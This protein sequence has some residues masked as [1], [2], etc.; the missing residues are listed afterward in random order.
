MTTTVDRPDVGRRIGSL[1][2]VE[3]LEKVTGRARYAFEAPIGEHCHAW[4]VTAT[5]GRGRVIDVD[6][7][8]ALAQPGVRAMLWHGNAPRLV[9]G[10]GDGFV[11]VLQ[12]DEVAF[13][14]Q[15]VGLVVADSP[16]VAREVART[17]PVRYADAATPDVVLRAADPRAY[18][19]GTVNAGLPGEEKQGDPS[20]GWAGAAVQVDEVYCTPAEHNVPMEPHAT[21]AVWADRRQLTVYNSSQGGNLVA[22]TLAKLFDLGAGDVRVVNH[23]VGGGFGSKGTPRPDVVLAAMAAREVDRPVRLALTRQHLFDLVGFRT[24]TIQRVRLGANTDGTL[25]AISHEATEATATIQEFAEQSTA[26]TRMMYA[27]PDRSTVHRV[28]ALDVP[29]PSWMRGPGETPGS[30][31]LECAMDELAERL[32]IDPVELRIRNEPDVEPESGLPWASRNLVACLRIGAE[33]FGWAARSTVPRARREGRWLVGVGM[34]S[35]TYPAYAGVSSARARLEPDGRYTFAINATDLGTGARTAMTVLAAEALDVDPALVSMQIGDTDLPR[36]SNAGG[37]AGTSSWGMAVDKAARSLRRELDAGGGAGSE[38][39]VDT[40]EE[41]RAMADLARHAFGAQFVEVR[42]DVEIGEVRVSRMTGVF[43]C[44]RIVNAA[45]ARSQLI[46]GM[47]MGLGMALLEEGVP[48]AEFGG[49]V[50]HDFA[51]YHIPTVAD[52]PDFDVS[53]IDEVDDRVNTIGT[54]GIG[55]IGIVGTAAAVANAVY[56]ATGVRV[57]DLPITVDKLLRD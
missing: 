2:R 16:E 11:W 30:F 29:I 24:P 1:P 46:G 8:A 52:T 31:A 34:A 4:P 6:T 13:R 47:T 7:E 25:I 37:S 50:N 41:V 20:G 17:V 3:G 22:A 49:F 32:G 27:A 10:A 51:T 42:V 38:V 23:H 26:M 28:V 43:A 48:D 12:S 33:R 21:T 45:P 53:W 55:E 39:T 57:R 40:R 14:G 5:I 36:G 9:E 56:N 15:V 18:V 44:G 19:P 54:K 35:S